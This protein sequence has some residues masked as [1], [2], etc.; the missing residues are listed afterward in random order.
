MPVAGRVSPVSLMAGPGVPV[1]VAPHPL[2]LDEA[3]ACFAIAGSGSVC[4]ATP[5]RTA[6][7]GIP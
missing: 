7:P 1:V 3:H 5:A 2:A 4:V 6:A